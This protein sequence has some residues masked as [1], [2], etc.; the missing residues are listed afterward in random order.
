[1]FSARDYTTAVLTG[2][3]QSPAGNKLG[4]EHCMSPL[5]QRRIM[6]DMSGEPNA[7]RPLTRVGI[8]NGEAQEFPPHVCYFQ[9]TGVLRT[10]TL[11]WIQQLQSSRY[12]PEGSTD[13][14][15]QPRDRLP[16]GEMNA[17]G[18]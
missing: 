18:L 7:G 12:P 16:L 14:E 17:L 13:T 10:A 8:S 3:D 1:M 11:F 9:A 15:H 4:R 2:H 6:K 5:F